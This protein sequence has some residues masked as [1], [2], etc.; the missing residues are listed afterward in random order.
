[1]VSLSKSLIYVTGECLK[2]CKQT[3]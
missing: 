2:W 1:M 3:R